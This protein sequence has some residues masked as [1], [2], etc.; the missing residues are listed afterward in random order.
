MLRVCVGVALV[1]GAALA[2]Q[3][4]WIAQGFRHP[5]YP[6]RHARWF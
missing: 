6:G 1:S 3:V 2:G 5:R 4:W